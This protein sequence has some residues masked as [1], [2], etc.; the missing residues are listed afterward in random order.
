[1][2]A[3]EDR[4]RGAVPAGQTFEPLQQLAGARMGRVQLGRP[5]RIGQ[6]LRQATQEL[7]Q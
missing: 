6:G 1:M 3:P 5:P 7:V 4:P 2:A